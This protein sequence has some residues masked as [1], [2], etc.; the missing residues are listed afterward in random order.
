MIEN[1]IY[2]N[3]STDIVGVYYVSE[4]YLFQENF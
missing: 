4:P 3:R 2:I 1:Q